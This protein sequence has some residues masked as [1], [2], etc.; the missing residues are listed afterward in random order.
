MLEST[1]YVVALTSKHQYVERELVSSSIKTI[2][3]FSFENHIW[4]RLNQKE[5]L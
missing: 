5:V 4:T 3:S 1:Q 2:R